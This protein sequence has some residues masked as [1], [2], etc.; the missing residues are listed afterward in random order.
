[1][2]KELSQAEIEDLAEKAGGY[3]DDFNKWIF[4]DGDNLVRLADLI[5]EPAL[6]EIKNLQSMVQMLNHELAAADTEIKNLRR[7]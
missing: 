3:L 7:G 4:R 1:M 2:P 6:M 5:L